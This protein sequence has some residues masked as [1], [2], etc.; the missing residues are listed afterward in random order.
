[1][2]CL[3]KILDDVKL[4]ISSLRKF[5]YILSQKD[6]INLGLE[7][8]YYLIKYSA[9]DKASLITALINKYINIKLHKRIYL[10]DVL[11]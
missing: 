1:M 4:N 6:K 2:S 8:N 11:N 7:Y 10:I 5:Y 3:I 9:V